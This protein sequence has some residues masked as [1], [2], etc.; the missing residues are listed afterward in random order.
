MKIK[1]KKIRLTYSKS[2]LWWNCDHQTDIAIWPDKK[3]MTYFMYKIYF[4]TKIDIIKEFIAF[5]NMANVSVN[6]SINFFLH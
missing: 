1:K 2:L 6:K 4:I 5:E 3:K